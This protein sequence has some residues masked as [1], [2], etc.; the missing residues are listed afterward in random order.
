M[1]R[2]FKIPLYQR[3]FSWNEE[4]FQELINDIKDAIDNREKNYFLGTILLKA[5]EDEITYEVVDGQQRLTSLII[6]LAVFRDY[7][8][9]QRMQRWLVDEGDEYAGIPTRERVK[10]W[11]DLQEIF[12][13]IYVQKWRDEKIH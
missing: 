2:F 9:E 1:N 8:N 3:P 5:E 12:F 13:R 10:V 4:N 7:L 6:L 11:R